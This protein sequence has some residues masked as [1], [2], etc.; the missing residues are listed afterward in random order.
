MNRY[1]C[2]G[3]AMVVACG[4]ICNQARGAALGFTGTGGFVVDGGVGSLQ[5]GACFPIACD[6]GFVG[7]NTGALLGDGLVVS[8]LV[9]QTIVED[10]IGDTTAAL[11][12]VTNIVATNTG[13]GQANDTLFLVSD[14]FDASLPG[15]AGVGI[16]GS[17]VSDAFGNIGFE[18]TQAQMNYLANPI[19]AFG[20][21]IN[22]FSLTTPATFLSCVACG[23]VG[24]W[25]AAFVNPAPGGTVQL[26]GAINFTLNS[27]DSI[28]LPGSLLI[29]DDD[30]AAIQ[31]ELPEPATVFLLGAA[32]LSAGL[33]RRRKKI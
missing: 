10:G 18:S 5:G 26:I 28:V 9:R 1:S 32:L 6:S 15:A 19:G 13:P 27:G 8:G 29:E 3:L 12:R 2:A 11:L 7:F 30:S 22:N 16:I 14:I 23:P 17:Y 4:A 21:P 31:A 24:F 25:E 20:G 33:A